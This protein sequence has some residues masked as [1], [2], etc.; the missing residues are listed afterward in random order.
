MQT[1]WLLNVYNSSSLFITFTERFS[2]ISR[3][4]ELLKNDCEQLVV[5]DFNLHHS[6]WEKRRCF[7]QHMMTDTLLNIITNARLKLLLKSDTITREAHNQFTTIDLVFSSEKIQFMIR[8][9][10]IWIDLHQRSNH[11]S[12]V[13]ELC[14]QTISVQFSTQRLW[15]KMNT[16]ALSAYL[17][18][19]LSLKHSL[20]D[21]SA[22]EDHREIY[23]LDKVIKLS[24]RLLK[25]K[26]LQS[27]NEIKMTANH[28]KNTRHIRS[29]KWISEAQRS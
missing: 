6:Y 13:T 9:C 26:L 7:T 1:L 23:L 27:S 28:M 15:K 5:E 16:E 10:E 29:M 8:K 18:I 3:L 4:N 25:S 19:H 14:L 11:L 12:I 2:T 22:T 24:K 17:Q 20:D 21:K